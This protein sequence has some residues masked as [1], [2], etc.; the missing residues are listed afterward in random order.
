MIKRKNDVLD[1]TDLGLTINGERAII[2]DRNRQVLII[3]PGNWNKFRISQI[4]ETLEHNFG[5]G[6]FIANGSNGREARRA[7]NDNA[8]FRHAPRLVPDGLAVAV[9]VGMYPEAPNLEGYDLPPCLYWANGVF[10]G[11]SFRGAHFVPAGGFDFCSMRQTEF[12]NGCRLEELVFMGCTLTGA[13]F[14]DSRLM[15]VRF[16]H[17]TVEGADFT[18]CLFSGSIEFYDCAGH[19]S[20]KWPQSPVS[21]PHKWTE[22]PF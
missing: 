1:T 19:N 2:A 22:S 3:D 11:A 12:I 18:D 16:Y 7:H 15:N 13:N 5:V 17:C 6:W 20:V 14:G 21:T 4:N 10:N 9:P 8:D